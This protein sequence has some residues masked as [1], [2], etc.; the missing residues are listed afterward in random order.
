MDFCVVVI[1][2]TKEGVK[3]CTRGDIGAANILIRQNNAGG[4]DIFPI[5]K[6]FY[7]TKN[8]TILSLPLHSDC[9]SALPEIAVEYEI[10]VRLDSTWLPR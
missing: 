8:P 5:L 6:I 7:C 2:V 1:S 9:P 4:R 3:F 10:E